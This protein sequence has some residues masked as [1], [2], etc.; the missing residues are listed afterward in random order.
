M[1]L[2][3]AFLLIIS[4]AAAQTPLDMLQPK[5]PHG[6]VDLRNVSPSS[7]LAIDAANTEL[8]AW[9]DNPLPDIGKYYSGVRVLENGNAGV[10][11]H[12]LN[13][14]QSE[15]ALPQNVGGGMGNLTP[16]AVESKGLI[17]V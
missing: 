10:P 4:L 13:F 5:A 12:L 1:R 6:A 7:A 16:V 8:V 11:E 3:L 9:Q 15:S 14:S 17:F 2:L